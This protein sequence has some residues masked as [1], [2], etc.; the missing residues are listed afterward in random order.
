MNQNEYLT[1]IQVT[2]EHLKNVSFTLMVKEEVDYIKTEP[3]M[4]KIKTEIS[5]LQL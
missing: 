4:M 1:N 3:T 2:G 5:S